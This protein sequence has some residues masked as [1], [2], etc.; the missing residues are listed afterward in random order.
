MTVYKPV[1]PMSKAAAE[2]AVALAQGK[3]VTGTNT[4]ENNGKVDVPTLKIDVKA[5]T[6][7]NVKDTVVADG[8]WKASEIC[9]SKYA[10]ACEKLGIE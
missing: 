10:A 4:K 1:V 7:D 6:A 8:Y 3:P 9:T 5:V 2:W